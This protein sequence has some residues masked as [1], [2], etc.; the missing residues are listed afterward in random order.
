[1]T[2]LSEKADDIEVENTDENNDA[3]LTNRYFK[4]TDAVMTGNS[5][6]TAYPSRRDGMLFRFRRHDTV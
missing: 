6:K 3:I 1:M 4:S 5:G 2:V